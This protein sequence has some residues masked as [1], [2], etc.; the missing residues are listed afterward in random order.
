MAILDLGLRV[1][2][3]R[4]P[5]QTS[6][7]QRRS[8][9]ENVALRGIV[10]GTPA[11]YPLELAAG[12][13][14]TVFDG[15]RTIGADATTQLALTISPLAPDRYR[16]TWTGTGANPALRVERALGASGQTLTLT[17]N[18]NLTVT[19]TGAGP[20]YTAV[21]VGDQVLIPGVA[22][23]DP[24]GPFDARNVGYWDVI[25][26]TVSSLTLARP[27]G[28]ATTGVTETV[29]VTTINQIIAMS[30]DR[31]QVHDQLAIAGGFSVNA[32]RTYPV[33]AV[34][35]RWVD[36]QS[37]VALAP[38]TA[39]LGANGLSVYAAARRITV[40][41]IDQLLG[42]YLNGDAAETQQVEPIPTEDG[43]RLGLMVLTG[44]VWALSV[45]NKSSTHAAGWIAVF[46]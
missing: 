6:N 40:L 11:Q 4:D 1:L 46:P 37:S 33:L 8:V 39:I 15:T 19:I 20:T 45:K 14:R 29:A 25:G 22:T 21:S 32:R 13:L 38:E 16:L 44:P 9:D 10:V 41:E 35:P 24:A 42:V 17:L 26:A 43:S 7:P 23:G 28:A 27:A 34:S 31:V 18:P 3:Y 2:S 12:E 36:V 30:P 5:T